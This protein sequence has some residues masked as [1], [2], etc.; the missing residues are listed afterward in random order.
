MTVMYCRIEGE[1]ADLEGE[2]RQF[3]RLH[4]LRVSFPGRVGR[5]RVNID[6]QKVLNT[7][8]RLK[9]IH[10]VA[11]ELGYTSGTVWRTLKAAGVSCERVVVERRG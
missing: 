6:V 4:A 9:N 8:S 2:I 3:C 7:Y 1:S 5:P 10:K 11:Q